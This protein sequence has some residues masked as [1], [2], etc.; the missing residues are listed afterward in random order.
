MPRK[1]GEIAWQ[2]S[3][4]VKQ[5]VHICDHHSHDALIDYHSTVIGT[6]KVED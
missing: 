4:L 1:T 5:F 2:Q 6:I 3:V